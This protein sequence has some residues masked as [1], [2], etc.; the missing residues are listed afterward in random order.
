MS[1]WGFVAAA[2]AITVIG[3]AWLVVGSWLSMRGSEALADDLRQ[4]P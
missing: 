1:H 3:T 4:K 2:F